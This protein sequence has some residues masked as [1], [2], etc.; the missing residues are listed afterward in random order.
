MRFTSGIGYA[1]D[2]YEFLWLLPGQ[3]KTIAG[4]NSLAVHQA[5]YSARRR[6]PELRERVFL[7]RSVFGG[8]VLER[9]T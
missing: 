9:V 1:R 2:L 6:H 4:K 5:L 3:S 7:A 8:V